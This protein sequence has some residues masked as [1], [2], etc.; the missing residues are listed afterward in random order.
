MINNKSRTGYRHREAPDVPPTYRHFSIRL[1]ASPLNRV[2]NNIQWSPREGQTSSTSYSIDNAKTLSLQNPEE[3]L[4]SQAEENLSFIE[5]EENSEGMPLSQ[6][7]DI[8][9]SLT[10][11]EENP[12][13]TDDA[14]SISSS[15]ALNGEPAL[16]K[17]LAE[18]GRDLSIDRICQI[19]PFP[20]DGFQKKAVER[21]LE[22]NQ[23]VVVCAPTGAG[24]TVIAEAA[25]AAVL[26]RGQRVIYTTPLKALSNQKLTEM[27]RRF[28]HTRCGLQTGDTSLNTEADIVIMTTEILRNIMYRTA[29]LSE[30]SA[31]SGSSTR[32]ARLGDVGLIVLDEVHYLGD[33]SRGSVWEEAIINCPR[34]IQLL[35]MSATVKNP[36]DLGGWI[37]KEHQPCETIKTRFRPVPLHWHFA[38]KSAK[39]TQVADLMDESGKHLNPS[40][41]AKEVL[42]EESRFLL[43]KAQGAPLPNSVGNR[44]G[45]RNLPWEQ[46]LQQIVDDD[47]VAL[48]KRVNAVRIPAMDALIRKLDRLKFL[49]A[50]WFILSRKDCDLNALKAGAVGPLTTLEEQAEIM[51]EVEALRLDQPEAIREKLVVAVKNGFASHHA[52]HLP[53]WKNLIERL[54]QHGYIK[55]VFATGTL[56]A[57]LNMPART[58]IISA[59][60]R[61]TDDGVK[62]LPHNDLLQMAG[63]A[64]RRG[65]DTEGHCVVLQNRF[66]GAEEAFRIIKGGPE[67]L[68]SQFS[69]SYGLVVNLISIYT[70]EEARAFIQRS[71]GNFLETEGQ[72]RLMLEAAKMEMAA[73]DLMEKYQGSASS[74][75]KEMNQAAKKARIH[76]QRLKVKAQVE[77][78]EAVKKILIRTG[79]PRRVVLHITAGV[80]D[81]VGGSKDKLKSSKQTLP[82][83]LVLNDEDV[84]SGMSSLGGTFCCLGAD[85]RLMKV[86]PIHVVSVLEGPEGSLD[87]EDDDVIQKAYASVRK[88]SW[89]NAAKGIATCQV[90]PGT[91]STAKIAVKLQF[92]A[93]DKWTLVENSRALT[94]EV[95]MQRKVLK[96]IMDLMEQHRKSSSVEHDTLGLAKRLLRK[97]DSIKKDLSDADGVESTWTTFN[98]VLDVLTKVGAIE[99]GSLRLLPLGLV[100]RSLQGQNELWL[101]LAL[102]NEAVLNLTGPQLA[103]FLGALLSSE[104]FRKPVDMVVS[105]SA[106]EEVVR[107]VEILEPTRQMLEALQ[108]DAGLSSWNE[109]LLVDYR[110]AGLV[111]AWAAGATWS[112]IMGDSTLDDGDMA[113]LLTR[114]GDLLRQISRNTYLLP[115]LRDVAQEALIGMDRKPISDTA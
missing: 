25:S 38:F 15:E 84:E 112:Q 30:E 4:A 93:S 21:L 105:Y 9:N 14:L 64:G 107:A 8:E 50:I 6:E 28:G 35:C 54:F 57:G 3:D 98:A 43:R 110:L 48:Q 10:T 5:L 17:L 52:G 41:D 115:D 102:S 114:T 104:V 51:R 68:K 86:S 80:D 81:K 101:S 13:T 34:H 18:G 40:L 62:L 7:L 22:S 12:Y 32:E 63:R 111:E 87:P 77:R 73:K 11:D 66:E 23:S 83:V 97:A 29:E 20:L 26:A 99:A 74:D 44:R 33:P 59:L 1:R 39:G 61:M 92:K 88:S 100:L 56:A 2:R 79:F 113:R 16:Q 106:S 91:S 78:I 89:S 69:A 109:S 72:Q 76:L 103:A 31:S 60:G 45:G 58:T 53:G 94:S 47:P 82:A 19:F 55:I 24:K 27:R 71:F 67:A 85:N 75:V 37:S 49:P 36:E 46:T 90:S 70:L 108:S 96:G 42:L 65:F 95:A